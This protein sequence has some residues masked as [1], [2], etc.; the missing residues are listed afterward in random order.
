[1]RE[2][3]PKELDFTNEARNARKA[4]KNF[5]SIST[6][7]YIPEV[8]SADKRVLIM[9]FI[10]GS[11]VDDLEYLAAHNINRNKVSLELSRIFSQMVY[12][13][14]WFHAVSPSSCQVSRC[15]SHV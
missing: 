9:E 13:D 3:L 4:M 14:G 11:R 2:N 8:I 10:E 12:I 15:D 6:S 1:M 5:E 7:L